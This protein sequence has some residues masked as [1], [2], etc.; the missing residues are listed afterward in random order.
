MESTTWDLFNDRARAVL[1]RAEQNGDWFC[2][3]EVTLGCLL[4]AMVLEDGAASSALTPTGITSI[5]VASSALPANRP[6]PSEQI[7][8]GLSDECQQAIRSAIEYSRT[9]G[10][11]F[12]GTAHLL[13]GM[14]KMEEGS[15]LLTTT[16]SDVDLDQVRKD[17][18]ALLLHDY[19]DFQSGAAMPPSHP[20]GREHRPRLPETPLDSLS[21]LA[22]HR[23]S[24]SS[25]TDLIV[26]L[27]RMQALEGDTGIAYHDLPG[28]GRVRV[29]LVR[30]STAAGDYDPLVVHNDVDVLC[31]VVQGMGTL[32]ASKD[33]PLSPGIIVRIPAGVSH[34]FVALGEPL[35][36][37]CIMLPAP[38]GLR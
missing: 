8:Q 31:H 6:D 11:Q 38:P 36:L 7:S 22:T 9:A 33:S 19:G 25:V 34:D 3:G 14:L 35:V 23:P 24:H 32:R 13:I 12:I 16:M 17:V 37:L 5:A 21:W 4:L 15:T 2:G 28:S 20:R 29:L 30:S 26:A 10:H 18:E 1:K 27:S